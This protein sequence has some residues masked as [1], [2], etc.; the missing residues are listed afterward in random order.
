[1]RHCAFNSSKLKDRP[2]DRAL[3]DAYVI[4]I[5]NP[6]I[7]QALLKEEDPDLAAAEKIIQVAERLEQDVRQFNSWNNTNLPIVA[8]LQQKKSISKYSSS[9][10]KSFS[11]TTSD[12][13]Q[14]C[15]STT[16]SRSECKYRT[17]TCNFCK[18]TDH[19]E[20]ACQKKEKK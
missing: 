12:L 9:N 3:R 15:G 18:R 20:R 7:R 10:G 11:T 2:Q 6:K 1:M 13:C 5:S 16:H 8:K 14:S 17:F 4:G 19:L